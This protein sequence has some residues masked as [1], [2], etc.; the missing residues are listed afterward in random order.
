M[1]FATQLELLGLVDD[2]V[3]NRLVEIVREDL[4]SP[5]LFP[6]LSEVLVRNQ[7]PARDDQGQSGIHVTQ[8]PGELQK[9]PDVQ[10]CEREQPHYRGD[11][12]PSRSHLREIQRYEDTQAH[13]KEQI[14]HGGHCV[15]HQVALLEHVVDDVC[16]YF[17]ARQ[18]RVER[19][20]EDVAQTNRRWPNK[21]YLVP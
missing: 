5:F 18:H 14:N 21:D 8:H 2:L 1:F 10:P 3:D 17:D 19:S 12:A 20:R 11:D 15:A 16:M 9:D 13:D 7:G 6:F 4:F